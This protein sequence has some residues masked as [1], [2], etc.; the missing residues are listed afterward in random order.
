MHIT[1]H[2]AVQLYNRGRHSMLWLCTAKAAKLQNQ[3]WK[4]FNWDLHLDPWLSASEVQPPCHSGCNVFIGFVRLGVYVIYCEKD[5]Y[6][7]YYVYMYITYIIITYIYIL[8][9]ICTS[10]FLGSP[11]LLG[12]WCFGLYRWDVIGS[13]RLNRLQ[14]LY[15]ELSRAFYRCPEMC[16]Y[17]R[18]AECCRI[19]LVEY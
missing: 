5:V 8:Q 16:N 17:R 19:L 12:Q 18:V 9:D 15:D 2:W 1:Y 3:R 10:W 7:L 13:K 4:H 11:W 6:T 14:G